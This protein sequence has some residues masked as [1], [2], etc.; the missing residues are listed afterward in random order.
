[1]IGAQCTSTVGDGERERLGKGSGPRE[2]ED[3]SSLRMGGMV[4]MYEWL[5]RATSSGHELHQQVVE[6]ERVFTN[7]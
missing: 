5:R 3:L 2:E 6:H 7:K 1:M 4:K